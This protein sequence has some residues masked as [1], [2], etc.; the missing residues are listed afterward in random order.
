[1]ITKFFSQETEFNMKK[2]APV[3]IGCIKTIQKPV[4]GNSHRVSMKP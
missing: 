1:M 3:F 2:M 4:R